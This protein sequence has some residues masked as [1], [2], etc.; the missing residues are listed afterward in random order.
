MCNE[1]ILRCPVCGESLNIYKPSARCENGHSFDI[2]KE[3][4]V[5]LLCTTK[6]GDKIG[7]DKLSARSRRNFL[8]KDY[9]KILRDHLQTIFAGCQGKLLDI[10]CG[11]GYY[12][13][14]LGHEAL[15]VYGFD[16]SKEMVRLAAKR[17]NGTYFVANM[18]SIPVADGSFDYATHLFAPFNEQEFA[19][20]L[21]PCGRLYTVI[22]GRF[23]LYGLKQAVYDIPYENDEKLPQTTALELVNT[24]KLSACISLNCAEDIDAVFR[25]TPYY[26]HTSAQDKEKLSNLEQLETPIEFII[27][28]YKK[29]GQ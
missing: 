17:K 10:C 5:N 19:R 7:D 20:I 16:I 12:T 3:G 1:S 18:A 8:N 23:H 28:E 4:Y 13:S 29:E 26:F 24:T 21:K 25:M 2:A 22:P 9:Y 6:S 15:N 27:A 14:A 11:E